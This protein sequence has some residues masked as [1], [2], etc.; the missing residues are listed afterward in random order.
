MTRDHTAHWRAYV[1]HLDPAAHH[2]GQRHT[3]QSE[4]TTIDVA[5]SVEMHDIVIGL[6]VNRYAFG[7]SR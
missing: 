3:Q 2:P 4:R 6:C 7:L 1:R 5:R